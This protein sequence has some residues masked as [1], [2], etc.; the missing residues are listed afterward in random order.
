MKTLPAM[1]IALC[2]F[3][4]AH[5]TYADLQ[6]SQSMTDQIQQFLNAASPSASASQEAALFSQVWSTSFSSTW[7]SSSSGD[8]LQG[9][10]LPPEIA[11]LTGSTQDSAEASK[12]LADKLANGSAPILSGQ[13]DYDSFAGMVAVLSDAV[14]NTRADAVPLI[15]DSR[16]NALPA[17]KGDIVVGNIM[18][19]LE[20][21]AA[22]FT[23]LTPSELNSWNGLATALNPIYRL[24]GAD[25]FQH[26]CSD[27]NQWTTFY[28]LYASEPDGNIVKSVI[29]ILGQKSKKSLIPCLQAIQNGQSAINNTAEAQYAGEVIQR[30]QESGL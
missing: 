3:Q 21:L 5:D 9:K 7:P 25:A 14:E 29:D 17:K 28:S 6:V 13:G 8:Y 26:T 23:S 12:L 4:L 18:L 30:L 20:R 15:F 22:G 27:L 19:C 1:A 2:L 24:I 16:K 11:A 10:K